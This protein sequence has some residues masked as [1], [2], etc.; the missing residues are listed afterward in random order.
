MAEK[1]LAEKKL[2]DYGDVFADIYNTLLFGKQ[3]LIPEQ[4]YAGSTESIYK[5]AKDQWKEQRRDTVKEYMNCMNLTIATLGIENQS[6][7]DGNE[8]IR[9]MGYDYGSY[10]QQIVDEKKLHPVITIVLNF[11]DKIWSGKKSL[12]E[13]LDIPSDFEGFV[14]D[15]KINVFDIAYLEDATIEAFTSDFKLVSIFF[16]NKRLGFDAMSDDTTE[17]KHPEEVKDFFTEE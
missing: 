14:Q 6:T 9:V 11:T 7:M 8:P 1:D 17:M 4:L 12:L 16:K 5:S 2:E 3:L 10:R 15:Y 13:L